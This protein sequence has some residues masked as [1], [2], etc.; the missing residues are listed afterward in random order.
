[1]AAEKVEQALQLN[2]E[3]IVST[4]ASC[5][6]HLQSYIDAQ[7]IPIKTYHIADVLAA[8]WPNI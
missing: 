1:M 4:D 6:M 2:A 8:G 5:L 3:A 7:K